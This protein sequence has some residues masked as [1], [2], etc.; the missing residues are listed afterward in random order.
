MI[1]CPW[2]RKQIEFN[3]SH[4]C[5]TLGAEVT[6]TRKWDERSFWLAV[7][8]VVLVATAAVYRFWWSP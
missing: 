4:H 6:P 2:C 3:K 8:G 7:V 5:R 1:T